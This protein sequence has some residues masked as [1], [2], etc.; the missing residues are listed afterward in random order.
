MTLQLSYPIKIRFRQA[1]EK[2]RSLSHKS[3]SKN[4]FSLSLSLQSPHISYEAELLLIYS[5]MSFFFNLYWVDLSLSLSLYLC[6][7]T[8]YIFE[9]IYKVK[10]VSFFPFETRT[11]INGLFI[12]L[13]LSSISNHLLQPSIYLLLIIMSFESS[14]LTY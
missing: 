9:W 8:K 7:L 3:L 10:F 5:T 11:E 6:N 12:R 1:S 14:F 13:N 4:L 2:S